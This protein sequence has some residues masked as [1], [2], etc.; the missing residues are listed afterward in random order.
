RSRTCESTWPACRIRR[1]EKSCWRKRSDS[2]E[3]CPHRLPRGE[4][5]ATPHHRTSTSA[6]IVSK[7]IRASPVRA[8]PP[9]EPDTRGLSPAGGC[10]YETRRMCRSYGHVARVGRMLGWA[11]PAGPARASQTL[12]DPPG[13]AGQRTVVHGA[14]RETQLRC[15][16]QDLL[17]PREMEP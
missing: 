3:T 8:L 13:A 6:I 7:R 16:V 12:A 9:A 14:G 10:R 5:A 11:G 4:P 1:W 17:R 2:S 15:V